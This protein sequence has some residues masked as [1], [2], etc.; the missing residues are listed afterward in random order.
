MEYLY[1]KLIKYREEDIYPM[2]MPG[3]KRNLELMDMVNPYAI[4]ITEIDG[5]DNLHDAEEI[6]LDNME[7]AA[8][9]Y[10]A[11]HTHYLINGSTSGLLVSIAAC[12]KK[13]DTVLVARNCHKAVYHAIFLNELVPIYLYPEVDDDYGIHKGITPEQVKK[14]LEE[15]PDIK[16]VLLTSPTY[17]GIVSDIREIASVVHS[18]NIPLIVDEA[19]GAHLGFSKDFPENSVTCGADMVIHSVHKTLPA[20][21]QTALL[22]SNGSLV[23]YDKVK[24]YLQIYQTSSPSYVLMS[25]ISN[26]IRIIK[27]QG[28]QLFEKYYRNLREFYEACNKLKH[29]EVYQPIKLQEEKRPFA[30]DPSKILIFTHHSS[31]N[32]VDLYEMLLN[33]YRIQCE[34]VSKNYVLAMTS[35]AD[36]KE[37]FNR[38]LEALLDIDRNISRE[39]KQA[40]TS[41]FYVTDLRLALTP[42]EAY[43]LRKESINLDESIGNIAAEYIYL[44]PPGI[45]LVVPGE[46]IT[47]EIISRIK[48]YKKAGLHIKGM[49]DRDNAT[50]LVVGEE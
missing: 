19:H 32:G 23:N 14:E 45:P 5:F 37:G 46:E 41:L 22:H 30:F 43:N 12:T 42:Y 49:K 50:I 33:R 25:G 27:E 31:I 35:L 24:M 7:E 36:T 28:R 6:L 1:D 48:E 9:L 15:N 38:L 8:Q 34:M 4:D 2:H 39:N 16:M 18:Y 29:L 21:T 26:C 20:F 44:Y 47:K 3:H 40:Q 10:H 17:E 11:E 13:G